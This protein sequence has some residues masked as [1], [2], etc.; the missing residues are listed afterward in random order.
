[1]KNL[2]EKTSEIEE[3]IKYFFKDKSLLT[4]SFVHRSFIN[5]NRDLI[6]ESNERLEF[7][8]DSILNLIVSEYLFLKLPDKE[9]GVLSSMRASLVNSSAC[10][11]Y[12]KKL[13]L[14]EYVLLGK[15]EKMTGGSK[16]ESI[17]AD[18]FEA[19]V[20]AIFLDG[21]MEST[22]NFLLG[23]FEK[24]FEHR[25]KTPAINHKAELQ[26]FCQKTY[27]QT[28]IYEVLKEEGP[29]HIKTFHVAVSLEDKE[30]GRGQG[31]SKK[32]AEATAAK[33]ALEKLGF[34]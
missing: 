9:E 15:G 13:Q 19:I 27:K 25:I 6:S 16:K 11:N 12:L 2:I 28:P 17:L 34:L 33:N 26:N 29:A 31:S 3:K 1:M 22:K 4:L 18:A 14:D 24:D 7:L 8:G 10:A 32:E 21:K 5:E 23:F 20:G 30:L